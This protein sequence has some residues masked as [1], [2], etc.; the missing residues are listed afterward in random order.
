M[1]LPPSRSKGGALPA[2]DATPVLR[3]R[4]G[5]VACGVAAGAVA[6]LSAPEADAAHLAALLGL[7]GADGVGE[8]TV[9]LALGAARLRV[10]VDGPLGLDSIP[11]A[12]LLAAPAA[13]PAAWIGVV[14]GFF[15]DGEEIGLLLDVERLAASGERRS[16]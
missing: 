11:P 14:A 10:R 6:A 4:A 7:E 2:A 8:R 5:G 15:R 3:F 13:L 1:S 12:R 9:A 16:P